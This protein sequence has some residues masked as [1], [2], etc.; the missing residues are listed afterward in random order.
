MKTCKQ[1]SL[2][3]GCMRLNSTTWTRWQDGSAHVSGRNWMWIYTLKLKHVVCVHRRLLSFGLSIFMLS[4]FTVLSDFM[5]KFILNA[6]CISET[7]WV[8]WP[9]NTNPGM[10]YLFSVII[11]TKHLYCPCLELVDRL[12]WFSHQSMPFNSCLT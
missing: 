4:T 1:R 9:F 3:S 2:N 7:N 8:V 12:I 11:R 10:W 5:A 6:T